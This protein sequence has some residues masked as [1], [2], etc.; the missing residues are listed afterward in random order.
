MGSRCLHQAGEVQPQP[1]KMSTGGSANKTADKTLHDLNASDDKD[2]LTAESARLLTENAELRKL[3]GLMQENLELRRT[4]GDHEKRTRNLSPPRQP[5][6]DSKDPEKVKQCQRIAG[7]IAF[8]LDR[9]IL[10]AVFLE[11][12]RLYGYRVANIKE[13]ILQVTTCPLT[14]KI[15]ENLRS[16]LTLRYHHTMDQLKKL[17]YD[18]TVHP[19][20]TE[21][22]VNTYGIKRERT[23]TTED[24]SSVNDPQFL[25]KMIAEYMASDNVE[26]ILVA[27]KCLAYLAKQDGK[28]LFIW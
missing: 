27:L 20:L 21:Y 1:G 14:G 3:M 5:R 28:C 2:A 17:G 19:Y 8:Q 18:P 10:C 11:R 15:D 24:P 25:G 26:D 7:E 23:P 9:R 12:Q 6:K 13:K 22:L 4:L 16:E